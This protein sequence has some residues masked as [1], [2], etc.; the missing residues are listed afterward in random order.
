MRL[1]AAAGL[2]AGRPVLT[3][4]GSADCSTAPVL[5]NALTNDR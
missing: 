2:V 3:P 1:R 4:S 5:Q